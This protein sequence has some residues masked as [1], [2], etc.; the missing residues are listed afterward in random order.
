[1]ASNFTMR[2]QRNDDDLLITLKGNF[3]GSS[4]HV[5]LEAIKRNC[6]SN[7]HIFVD[8]N[9]L[10]DIHPFGHQVLQSSLSDMKKRAAEIIF[11]G[12]KGNY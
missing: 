10:K 9:G 3:D 12:K 8:T 6:K 4:A 2:F 5:L 11:S 7:H 1:M